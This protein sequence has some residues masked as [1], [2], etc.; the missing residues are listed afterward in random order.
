MTTGAALPAGGRAA[1]TAALFSARVVYAFSWYNVGAVLPLIGS[2][3][4][5]GPAALGLVLAAFLVGAGLFQVP[6][7]IAAVRWGSR[8]VSLVGL[9]VMGFAATASGVAPNWPS[10][11]LARFAAGVGAA[12]FFSPALSLIA[13]YFPPGERGV[14]IGLYN[15]GFSVGAA[16]GLALGALI[17][18][19]WG[20]SPAL[21]SGGLALLAASAA[22]W[23]LLP[24]QI[25][26]PAAEPIRAVLLR[27]RAVL[28]SPSIWA[29]SLGLTGFWSAIYIVAQYFVVFAGA[30]DPA[31][32]LTLAAGLVTLVIVVSFP[33]G[34]LGGWLGERSRHRVRL[35]ALIGG[36]TGALVAAVP[37]LPLPALVLDLTGLGV[38]DGIGFAVLYLIPTYL[39]Q[40]QANSLAL[41]VA[42]INSIQ[43]GLGSALAAAFGVFVALFGYPTAWLLAG[44]LACAFLPL[45]MLVETAASASLSERTARSASRE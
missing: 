39:P 20:W 13:S 28:R 4:A 22:C 24:R 38:L 36:A 34:P 14:V 41:G 29:L 27:S 2:A 44:A 8:P 18:E 1:P 40:T 6:A 31:W 23:A 45:L 17:G 19:H 7:G 5:A 33:A 43:V 26:E 25:A 21:W 10:L 42:V 37:F 11:A 15:G 16:L 32:G 12:F 30:A 9:A 35:L 3:F